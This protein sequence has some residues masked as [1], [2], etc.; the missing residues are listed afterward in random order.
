MD[1]D[2]TYDD[3]EFWKENRKEKNCEV[4]DD[5]DRFD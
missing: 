2:K 3:Y 5:R 1:E 4:R